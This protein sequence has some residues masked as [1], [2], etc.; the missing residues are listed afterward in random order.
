MMRIAFI[1]AVV[2]SC[3]VWAGVL[4]A[5]GAPLVTESLPEITVVDSA[6]VTTPGKSVL[7]RKTLQALPQG[8]GAITDL[9]KVLSGIQFSESDNSSLT[10]GEI[11]P[12]EISISGGRVYDNNF[13]ID[14]VGNNSLLD[15]TSANPDS[16]S[17]VPGH[18]QELF[19]D[20]SLIDTISI[21]RS[22]ISARYSGFSGG[23]ID[24]ETRDPSGSFSGEI[25]GRT[26]RSE[27]TS[28]HVDCD[29]EEDFIFSEE[30][31]RQPEFR[32]YY[33]NASVNVPLSE[34]MGVL[35]SY[36]RTYSQIPLWNFGEKEKQYRDM[37]N[38]FIKYLYRPTDK[39]TL[40]LTY[41]STPYEGEYFRDD[42]K[43]S[44]YSIEG[45]G[46]SI[47]ANLEH[48]FSFARAE[49][50][51][52]WKQSE[53]NRMAPQN[54]FIYR[55]TDSADWGGIYSKKG[56]YG[57]IEKEQK[58]LTL[59]S[60]LEFEPVRTGW[61]EHEWI[62]GLTVERVKG[63]EERTERTTNYNAWVADEDVVCSDGTLD[64]IAGEQF[65]WYKTIYPEYDS[66]AELTTVIA[67]LE[68]SIGWQRLTWR[69]G[70]NLSYNDLNKNMD[71]AWR[72]TLFFDLF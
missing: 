55:N 23:V 58:T 62:A 15:P 33:G 2:V 30:A 24:I 11:L 49:F 41:L 3:Q 57:D 16:T 63:A 17:L 5:A 64:C 71:Y 7:D 21:H 56:G 27:W 14:G 52:G 12:A 66:D 22:N 1:F 51:V 6:A 65:A 53:N 69:P 34:T 4:W 45:G 47:S 10:G 9:L 67:Y 31:D 60:H 18:S 39:T 8:D 70:V 40:R 29:E 54:Y 19:L 38:H 13:M 20:A 48:Q 36:S 28:F 25:T 37:E 44:S 35:L 59:A 72:N 61:I 32:K 46:W 50:I 43:N 68:D 26:T 42:V